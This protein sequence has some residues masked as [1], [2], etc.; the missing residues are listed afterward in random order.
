[1][2]YVRIENYNTLKDK[3]ISENT[4]LKK[5]NVQ[6]RKWENDIRKQKCL[7]NITSTFEKR[8]MRF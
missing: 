2:M 5:S 8:N 4:Y 6:I 1:M 7:N 3:V